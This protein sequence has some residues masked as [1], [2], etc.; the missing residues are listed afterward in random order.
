MAGRFSVEAVFKAVDRVTAPVTKMQ[1]KI[2]KFTRS[3]ERNLRKVNKAF[4]KF[5]GLLPG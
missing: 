4:G 1:N 3:V 5:A 2:G